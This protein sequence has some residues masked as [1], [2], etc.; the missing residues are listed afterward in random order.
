[1]E[2]QDLANS[3]WNY[4]S[5]T[6]FVTLS[7]WIKASVSQTYYTQ[8]RT[9]DGTDQYYV[10]EQALT[11]NTWKKVVHSIPGDSDLQFDL[12]NEEGFY[13]AW[14]PFRGT[15]NTGS[16]TL[17]QWA[18]W[19]SSAIVPDMTST[20]YTTNDSTIEITGVQ[21]ELGSQATAFEHHTFSEELTFCHRYHIEDMAYMQWSGYAESGQT[22]YGWMNFPVKMRANPTCTSTRTS[23]SGFSSDVGSVGDL[24]EEGCGMGLVCNSSTA[25]AYYYR[26]ITATAE[27]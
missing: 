21:L 5:S 2:A 7:Y 8:M 24:N 20:W 26:R 9:Q 27:L 14:Y 17:N 11:A 23:E 10:F 3:G 18:N 13:I 4:T 15:D 19:N 1:M 12:N 6:N 25:G 16:V 22:Y